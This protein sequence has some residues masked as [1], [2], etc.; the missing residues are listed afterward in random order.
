[1]FSWACFPGPP[2]GRLLD[3]SGSGI[4]SSWPEVG[5]QVGL[6]L[7]QGR[8][9]VLSVFSQVLLFLIQMLSTPHYRLIVLSALF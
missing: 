8:A 3:S 5:L 9:E 6:G 1:M 2:E 7:V 4:P